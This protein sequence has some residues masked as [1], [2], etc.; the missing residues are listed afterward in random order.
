MANCHQ[1]CNNYSNGGIIVTEIA[2]GVGTVTVKA[3]PYQRPRGLNLCG[4]SGY[5]NQQYYSIRIPVKMFAY[6]NNLGFSLQSIS[7]TS[8]YG[9]VVTGTP[10]TSGYNA[11][12]RITAETGTLQDNYI[13]V[14]IHYRGIPLGQAVL[15]RN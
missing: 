9:G 12:F 1:E 2:N 14:S 6:N 7:T 11:V 3:G 5:A 10:G 8:P 13:N 15:V 4:G